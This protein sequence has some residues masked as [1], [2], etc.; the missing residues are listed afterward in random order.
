VKQKTQSVINCVT[1]NL[2]FY[3]HHLTH[4]ALKAPITHTV[5]YNN[6]FDIVLQRRQMTKVSPFMKPRSL[7][8]VTQSTAKQLLVRH[9]PDPLIAP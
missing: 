3:V 1:G 2:V 5:T 7:R 9:T 6:I 4:L 8:Q